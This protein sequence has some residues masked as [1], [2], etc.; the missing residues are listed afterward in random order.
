MNFFELLH[1]IYKYLN[2]LENDKSNL[3]WECTFYLRHIPTP[4]MKLVW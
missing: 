4:A 2:K 3:A 1:K